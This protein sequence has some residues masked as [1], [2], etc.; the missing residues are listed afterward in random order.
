VGVSAG[1]ASDLAIVMLPLGDSA[2]IVSVVGCGRACV[3][4]REKGPEPSMIARLRLEVIGSH[5]R[6]RPLNNY[7]SNV[8]LSPYPRRE[9]K[10]GGHHSADPMAAFGRLFRLTRL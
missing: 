8:A 6:Q 7:Q 2:P 10:V 4:A 9:R 1:V 5:C 3:S